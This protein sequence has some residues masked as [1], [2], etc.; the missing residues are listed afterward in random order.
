MVQYNLETLGCTSAGFLAAPES[1]IRSD[2][3][4]LPLEVSKEMG[5]ENGVF[6]QMI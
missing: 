3:L 4:A 5:G 2:V 6:P 1:L